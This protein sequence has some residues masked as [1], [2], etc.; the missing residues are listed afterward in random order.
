MNLLEKGAIFIDGG[1]LNKVLKFQ[2]S[3]S[4]IDYLRF[5]ELICLDLQ[6]NR[7]RTYFYYCLPINRKGNVED[8]E[9]MINAQKFLENLKRLPRFEVKL[10][11]LQL[12]GNQFRQKM[13]DILISLDITNMAFERQIEHVI[14]IA[15]DSDFVPAIKKAKNYGSIVHL[16]YHPSSIHNELLDEVDECHKIDN[17]LINKCLISNNYEQNGL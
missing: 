14:I 11:K 13:I 3:N 15:G 5:S 17:E 4:K 2:F 1:Y 12:I 7:L 8:I 9:R 16:Y 10:G 6:L